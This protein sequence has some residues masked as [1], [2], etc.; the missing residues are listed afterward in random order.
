MPLI[1]F[2]L[3]H[4]DALEECPPEVS[5]GEVAVDEDGALKE[6]IG[7]CAPVKVD[8]LH[9]H[10]QMGAHLSTCGAF[11]LQSA[12]A[13]RGARVQREGSEIKSISRTH[14]LRK[15]VATKLELY[16]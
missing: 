5:L 9:A 8:I 6:V 10:L 12:A 14:T 4:G 2:S 11:S 16:G 15:S 7:E 13:A 3:L 1:L